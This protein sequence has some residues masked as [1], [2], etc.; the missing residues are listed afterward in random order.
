M[1]NE[2]TIKV[3]DWVVK[4]K[5]TMRVK[6]VNDNML[7][8]ADR[9]IFG[10][11]DVNCPAECVR[12]W[13]IDDVELGD[14]LTCATPDGNKVIFISNGKDDPYQAF[15]GCNVARNHVWFNEVCCLGYKEHVRPSVGEE[16]RLLNNVLEKQH[17]R[18]NLDTL[19]LERIKDCGISVARIKQPD[20]WALFRRE[21]AKDILCAIVGVD[22]KIDL[23]T[24]KRIGQRQV[25]WA[26][27]FA[28]ELIRQLK[29]KEG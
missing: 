8:V 4:D 3:G 11:M 1:A 28:D 17:M 16:I 21:A 20:E 25:E 12:P 22:R 29:E 9:T 7:R 18:W 13:T 15:A 19:K 10:E 26:M 5:R 24:D 2:Q 23:S 6:E 27:H 14:Y